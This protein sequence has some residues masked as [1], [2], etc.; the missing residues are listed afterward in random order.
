M[1]QY[2]VVSSGADRYPLIPTPHL[3]DLE[4]IRHLRTGNTNNIDIFLMQSI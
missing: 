4:R 2:L 1:L 3:L